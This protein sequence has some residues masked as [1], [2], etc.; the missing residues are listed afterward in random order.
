ML[1]LVARL[2]CMGPSTRTAGASLF[3]ETWSER[4]MTYELCHQTLTSWYRWHIFP[5]HTGN[6]R[7]P[8]AS[9]TT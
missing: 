5:W 4:W 8:L 2:L 1:R 6:V 7:N 3:R 9:C